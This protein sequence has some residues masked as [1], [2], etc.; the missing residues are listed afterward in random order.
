MPEA[1]RQLTC[2]QR[3]KRVVAFDRWSSFVSQYTLQFVNLKWV[4]IFLCLEI[5]AAVFL[6]FF[7]LRFHEVA[8]FGYLI[9][10]WK[11]YVVIAAFRALTAVAGMYVLFA[12]DLQK[13]RIFY[14]VLFFNLFMGLVSMRPAFMLDCEC[15]NWYQC[16]GLSAFHSKEEPILN[17]WSFPVESRFDDER[18]IPVESAPSMTGSSFIAFE[19][20]PEEK[21]TRQEVLTPRILVEQEAMAVPSVSRNSLAEVAVSVDG[22]AAMRPSK[23]GGV[24]EIQDHSTQ[25]TMARPIADSADTWDFFSVT[26]SGIRWKA[27]QSHCRRRTTI[28]K[29]KYNQL[30]TATQALRAR[31]DVQNKDQ[32]MPWLSSILWLCM[33]DPTCTLVHLALTKTPEGFNATTCHLTTATPLPSDTPSANEGDT[34]FQKNVE[35]VQEEEEKPERKHLLYTNVFQNMMVKDAMTKVTEYYDDECICSDPTGCRIYTDVNGQDRYWCWVE[36]DRQQACQAKT[37]PLI[38]DDERKHH[39][40]EGLCQQVV[41][42]KCTGIG[43]HPTAQDLSNE[44]FTPS[45]LW[46]NKMNYGAECRRWHVDD[47]WPWCFVGHDSIC[48]DRH[49]ENRESRHSSQIPPELVDMRW[50]WRSHLPCQEDQQE[51]NVVTAAVHCENVALGTEIVLIALLVLS[52]PMY[53]AVFQFISNRCCDHTETEEQ[54]AVEFSDE[55]SDEDEPVG[56]EKRSSKGSVASVDSGTAPQAGSA[57]DR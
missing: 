3:A 5:A 24:I 14:F 28:T 30:M 6:M 7:Y 32:E 18:K 51:L 19:Q 27:V 45:L 39:W 55:E 25:R 8:E 31:K 26:P 37:V 23:G 10:D 47:P 33:E 22:I 44:K 17:P 35:A 34:W 40:A 11:T 49:P 53:I 54:F 38:W 16:H 42:C 56:S 29:D 13:A 43:M 52:L 1:S 36:H 41:D 46:D 15:T 20:M 4:L 50:Q 21:A 9:K 2:A 12:R 48:P 57:A